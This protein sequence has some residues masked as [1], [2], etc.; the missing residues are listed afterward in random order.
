MVFLGKDVASHIQK[1]VT[2]TQSTGKIGIE[3]VEEEI[4]VII[5][6]PAYAGT[7]L[8]CVSV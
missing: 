1:D 7:A 3:D 5:F 2:N 8:K 4:N 6:T